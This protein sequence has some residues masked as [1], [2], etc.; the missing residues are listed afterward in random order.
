MTAPG[1]ADI[2]ATLSDWPLEFV[3]AGPDDRPGIP[4]PWRPVLES[5]TAE[6]RCRAAL[7][8]WN[9]DFLDLVP[10]YATTLRS[11]LADVRVHLAD[12]S[13]VLVYLAPADDGG[14]VSWVGQDPRTFGDP[15]RFWGSFPPALRTFLAGVHTG[16][17]SGSG[18]AYGPLPPV[19]Q[20]TLAE[21]A[22]S[23][24]GIPGWA[25]SRIPSTRLLIVG[26]DEGLM[27]YCVSPDLDADQLAVV[28]EGDIDPQPAGNALDELLMM[29]FVE[30]SG[31]IM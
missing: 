1:A 19:H 4:E 30:P 28:Y 8:L 2:A 24:D 12:G 31:R 25:D 14:L 16:F 15:P 17:T 29:G 10:E 22:E 5:P 3:E 20:V 11:R 27:F 23:P 26:T 21:L 13:P 9:R 7:A 6:A 18:S